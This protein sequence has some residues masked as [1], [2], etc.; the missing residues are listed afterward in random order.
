MEVVEP[1]GVWF[2]LPGVYVGEYAAEQPGSYLVEMVASRNSEQIGLD[3]VAFRREDVVL[4]GDLA[5][6]KAVKAAYR[7]DHLPSE[8]EVAD[9]A[10]RWRPYRTL[11]CRYLWRSLG[12]TP[13]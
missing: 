3:T 7:L 11:A 10:E 12:A 4:P 9:I 13:L 1:D 6:R 5:L 2:P 8:Q